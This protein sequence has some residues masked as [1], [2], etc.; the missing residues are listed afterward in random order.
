MP[1][2]R[3]KDVLAFPA[4]FDDEA[5]DAFVGNRRVRAWKA[6]A[7]FEF[8]CPDLR[9]ADGEVVSHGGTVRGPAGAWVVKTSSGGYFGVAAEECRTVA[10]LRAALSSDPAALAAFD[11]KVR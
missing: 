6:P 2:E 11:E 7:R 8:H 5:V 1:P 4:E 10:E 3:V 9:D